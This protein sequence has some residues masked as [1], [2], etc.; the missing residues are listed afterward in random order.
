MDNTNSNNPLE[1]NEKSNKIDRDL[2]FDHTNIYLKDHQLA[3]IQKCIDIEEFKLCNFGIMNDKPG[4]GKTFAILGFILA[5][6]LQNELNKNISTTDLVVFADN[7]N[8]FESRPLESRPLESRPLES[9]PLE[10]RPLE[11]SPLELDPQNFDKTDIS[12]LNQTKEI[13]IIVVPQNIIAQWCNSIHQFSNGE[14]IKYKKFIDYN[15]I[16]DL[17]NN[18]TDLFNYDILITTSL[19]YN[20]IATTLSSNYL[21]VKRVFFDEIDSISSFLVNEINADFIWFVSASFRH[22]EL[23]IYTDK[24]SSDLFPYIKC[25]C[26]DTYIDKMFKIVNPNIYKIICKNIYVDNIFSGILSKEEYRLLNAMDYTKLKKKFYHKIAQNDKEA[27]DF[28]VKDKIEII[29]M[30]ELRIEDLKKSIESCSINERLNSLK[31]QLDES[32]K[33]LKESQEKL[34]LIKERLKENNCCPLCYNEYEEFQKKVISPCCKNI[35]CFECTNNWFTNLKKTNCIYCNTPETKMEDYIIVKPTTN[36]TCTICDKEYEADDDKLYA[37]CC[38]K[39]TCNACLQ[40]WYTKLL[41]RNCLFC[42]KEGITIED[43]RNEK[44]HEEMKLNE[45]NGIKYI[46]KTKLEVIQFFIKTKLY[47]NSKVIFCSDYVRIFNDIKIL[48]NNYKIEYIELDDGNINEIEES[49]KSFTTGT[50]KVM[51]LNSNLFGCGLNLQCTTDIVFLHNPNSILEQ[52]I[53][54]RAQRPGR[55]DPLNVWYL[56]HENERVR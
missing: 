36:C 14:K 18:E 46:K 27:I 11:S 19:Y 47:G 43:F 38:E 17:Y 34:N 24:I 5:S 25:K 40:D 42:K 53:V 55:L 26:N 49:I 52:Q 1:L 28:L 2:L 39:I 23:G 37:K 21:N 45:Q 15:D 35:I 20:V 4:A 54:G 50:I 12:K 13:N 10:S 51:L 29:E 41:K 44:Q 7:V 9:R 16:L 33:S 31:S 56:M 48:F 6:K 32:E 22:S 8:F 3:I 30:E